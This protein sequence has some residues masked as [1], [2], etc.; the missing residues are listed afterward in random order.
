MKDPLGDTEQL[1]I[2]VVYLDFE[3]PDN[4]SEISQYAAR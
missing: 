3:T 2:P 4:T 1:G